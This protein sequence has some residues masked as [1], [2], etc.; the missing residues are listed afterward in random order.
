MIANSYPYYPNLARTTP[1][2]LAVRS[3]KKNLLTAMLVNELGDNVN[4]EDENGDTPILLAAKLENDDFAI[5]L[6]EKG[7][8][9]TRGVGRWNCFHIAAANDSRHLVG[10]LGRFSNAMEAVCMKDQ[11]GYTPAYLAYKANHWSTLMELIKIDPSIVNHQGVYQSNGQTSSFSLI[12]LSILDGKHTAFAILLQGDISG[13]WEE[14]VETMPFNQ[15]DKV[16][17]LLDLCL[18]RLFR[19]QDNLSIDNQLIINAVLAHISTLK[20]DL[21]QHLLNTEAV[22]TFL[23][24]HCHVDFVKGVQNRIKQMKESI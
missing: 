7:A 21:K 9:L 11:Y 12:H 24:R 4:C 23:F 18:V 17:T 16:K 19:T 20:A 5:S 14:S 8:K 13:C 22:S 3:Q 2:H 1:L 15:E 10:H 6:A